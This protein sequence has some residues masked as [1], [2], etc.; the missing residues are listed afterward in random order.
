MTP[1]GRDPARNPFTPGFGALPRVF[2]G[3]RGEFADL[4]HMVQRLRGGIHSQPRLVVGDRGM[5]KTV[6]LREFEEN[7]REDGQWV[8]RAVATP[9]DA[10]I[11]RLS[12]RLGEVLDTAD[13]AGRLTRAGASALRRLAGVTVAGVKVDLDGDDGAPADRA[14][15][16]EKLLV[17][18]GHLARERGLALVL[19]IDEA[20]SISRQAL[21]ELFY[22]L[23]EAQTVSITQRDPLSGAR[24]RS[25]L[26][27][28]AVVAG[29]PGLIGQLKRA[30]ST[31][32][33]R[34][35]LVELAL[36]A[37][38]DVRAALLAFAEAGGAAFDADALDLVVEACG[39]YPYF[40]HLVGEAVWDAGTGGVITATDASAGIAIARPRL[41]SFYDERL[42]DLTDLQRRYLDA[43]AALEPRSRTAGAIAG[44]LGS[45]SAQLASTWQALT[46]RHGLLRPAGG[47]GLLA[48]ALPGLDAHLRARDS[49]AAETP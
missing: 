26:P 28:G 39:G 3:R 45:T 48:F 40:L 15:A 21:G 16:L 12:S 6:L 7:L 46:A 17:E 24:V 33:E 34:S 35:R 31:F 25:A 43:A 32:G 37:E 44:A 19:L 49:D 8:V 2:A 14:L 13:V 42:R 5:G 38:D 11:G 30:G 10:V 41:A 29:L 36:L 18:V 1:R 22:A 23:Q 9:G 20:Q 27:V 4:D 47:E